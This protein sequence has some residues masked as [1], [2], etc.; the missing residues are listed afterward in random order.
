MVQKDISNSPGFM[1]LQTI[2]SLKT[3]AFIRWKCKSCNSAFTRQS[4][5]PT[6]ELLTRRVFWHVFRNLCSFFKTAEIFQLFRRNRGIFVRTA[7]NPAVLENP[8]NIR[9]FCTFL[10]RSELSKTCS[11][12]APKRQVRGSNPPVDARNSADFV[13]RSVSILAKRDPLFYSRRTIP[14]DFQEPGF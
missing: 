4:E 6:S 12:G 9:L 8:G 5:L 7:Q 2:R 3:P 14:T 1:F 10:N 11:G 13:S